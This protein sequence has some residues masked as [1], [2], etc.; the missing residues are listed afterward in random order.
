[1]FIDIKVQKRAKERDDILRADWVNKLA[2]WD[3]SQLMFLDESAANERTA[4][5]KY[6]WAPIGVTPYVSQPL[7]RSE[8][9][10]LLPLYTVDGFL[11]WEVV[12]GSYTAELFNEFVR[13]KVLPLCNEYPGP[14]SIL[15]MDNASIHHSEVLLTP[16]HRRR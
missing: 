1:M 10:S 9:W 15:V 11:T 7:K 12:H 13:E 14:R 16:F 8:R 5:R 6:G 4:D 2:T 3:A